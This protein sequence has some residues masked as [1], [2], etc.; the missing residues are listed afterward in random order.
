MSNTDFQKSLDDI[1]QGL[2]IRINEVYHLENAEA[3]KKIRSTAF[4]VELQ[5]EES[6]LRQRE[7][8]ELFSM[9]QD[10]IETGHFK[11]K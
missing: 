2:A 10:E 6:D 8:E 5:K 1:I 4:F 3:I 9:Y 7:I 11:I